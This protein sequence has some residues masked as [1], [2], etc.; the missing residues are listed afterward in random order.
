MRLDEIFHE[1]AAA[2]LGGKT[3]NLGSVVEAPVPKVLGRL[4]CIGG[5]LEGREMQIDEAGF[6]IGRDQTQAQ[7]VITDPRVMPPSP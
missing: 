3:R 5:P 4:V 7:L 1:H 2:A 6:V